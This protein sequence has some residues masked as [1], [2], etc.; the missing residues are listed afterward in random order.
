[1]PSV[2]LGSRFVKKHRSRQRKTLIRV[3]LWLITAAVAVVVLCPGLGFSRWMSVRLGFAQV[4]A[5]SRI[6]GLVLLVMVACI[7]LAQICIRRPED[8]SKKLTWGFIFLLVWAGLGVYLVAFPQGTSGQVAAADMVS[9]RT[10]KIVSFNSQDTVNAENLRHLDDAFHADVY[11]FPEGGVSTVSTATQGA[12]LT[13]TLFEPRTQDFDG[14]YSEAV[15]PTTIFVRSSAGNFEQKPGISLSFGSVR[16]QSKTANPLTILGVH[17]APPLPALMS[18]WRNDLGL[19]GEFDRQINDTQ[20]TIVVGDFNATM[21]HG[22]MADLEN[23]HDAAQLARQ[24]RGTWPTSW[25][26]AA[27]A[28]IDHILV[29]S[30]ISVERFETIVLDNGD[31]RAI[32]TELKVAD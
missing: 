27:S 23:L 17:T 30:G 4:L 3:L 22:E 21:R 5:F 10:L 24:E 32:F 25:P 15:A 20:S 9:T 18:N 14:L 28:P 29:S 2:Q 26:S 1:M 11:V 6:A 12:G 7:V 31:H 19:V 13:G 16:L 8:N